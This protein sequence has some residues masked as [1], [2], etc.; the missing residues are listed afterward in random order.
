MFY[1]PTNEELT[2]CQLQDGKVPVLPV[3]IF[4]PQEISKHFLLLHTT[5]PLESCTFV[6]LD[7]GAQPIA[8]EYLRFEFRD[9][10]STNS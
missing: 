2:K 6:G 8:V 1:L 4:L 3:I 9:L 10:L 5:E 7:S